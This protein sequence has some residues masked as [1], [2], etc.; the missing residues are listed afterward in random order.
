MIKP[1]SHFVIAR[2]Y[3]LTVQTV[4]LTRNDIPIDNADEFSF[5][6]WYLLHFLSAK[7]YFLCLLTGAWV[8]TYFPLK[9]SVGH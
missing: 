5:P 3:L 1:N 7:H 9:P 2:A 8:K 4:E 6:S